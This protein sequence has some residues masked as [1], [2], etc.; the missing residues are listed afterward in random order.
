MSSRLAS[1]GHAFARVQAMVP[2]ALS[3]RCGSGGGGKAAAPPAQLS[4]PACLPPPQTARQ[5]SQKKHPDKDPQ[6]EGGS[7]GGRTARQ[8]IGWAEREQRGLD[9]QLQ[10]ANSALM[11]ATKQ[12]Q[13]SSAELNGYVHLGLAK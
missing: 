5:S 2:E 3:A 4:Q 13:A 10:T 6:G 11:H 1:P 9:D 12:C 7:T 8:T